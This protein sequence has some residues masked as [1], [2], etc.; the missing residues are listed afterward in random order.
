MIEPGGLREVY[1]ET[2]DG[3]HLAD[4]Y[5][6]LECERV[7]LVRGPGVD[8]WIDDEG[9]LT[10]RDPLLLVENESIGYRQ[11]LM[12]SVLVTGGA[13]SEGETLPLTEAQSAALVQCLTPGT[14]IVG[15]HPVDDLGNPQTRV[16]PVWHLDVA[17]LERLL[18]VAR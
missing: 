17:R 4:M 10:Q 7:D 5:R 12:G 9:L 8:L 11:W 14:S 16:C 15:G 13:D 18:G 6:L 1:L 3:N 2:K